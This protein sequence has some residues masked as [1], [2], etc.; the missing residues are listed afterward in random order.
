[1]TKV[2]LTDVCE[3]QG[4]SQPPK[5]EW[6]NQPRDGYIRMLQIRDFTQSKES[7]IEYVK[8]TTTMKTCEKDDILIGRYGASVGKIL[9]GFA[10]AYNVAIM[11]TIP[12]QK[13]LCKKYLKS[14]LQSDTF[15]NYILNIGSRAAQAGFN[16]DDLSQIEIPL[17]PLAEQKKIA[18]ELDKISGLIAKR[19][20]QI[21]KLDLLVKAKFVEMFGDPVTNPMGWE[22]VQLHET[23][24]VVSGI[25]K[26]RKSKSVHFTDVPY[27]AVSNVKDG[28]IDWTTVKSIAAT[29]DEIEQY[30]ILP[31][32][33]LMTEGGDPDK[34]GRGSIIKEVPENCIHQNHIFR[35]RCNFDTL[36]PH[37]FSQ[38]LKHPKSKQYFLWCAKQTTG[39]AS[40]NMKQLRALPVLRPPISLQIQLADFVQKT[41]QIKSTM[42]KS[43]VGLETL[44]KARMQ[45]YFE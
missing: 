34:L 22:I 44:Y 30:K 33:V 6:I 31:N 36:N 1:M 21:K 12:N 25:T 16:K 24:H 42:Q 8:H 15:Q 11:K 35:V 14:F 5:D 13:V 3:F 39:I 32:D 28:Y 27:M 26:G 40:I 4:G 18:A 20:S 43:L 2:L 45:E 10:G 37:F 7:F 19:K 38:Y 17:P 9:S 23:A 29:D 41:E